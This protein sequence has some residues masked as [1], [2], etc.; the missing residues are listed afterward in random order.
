MQKP[1]LTFF[2][3]LP[4]DALEALFDDKAVIKHLKNLK[5]NLSLGILDL[6]DQRANVVKKLNN[7]GVPVTAWLLLPEE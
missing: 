7:A 2:T 5:A 4:A 6:S 3:E 1:E